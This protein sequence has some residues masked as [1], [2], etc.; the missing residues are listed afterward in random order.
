MLAAS[1]FRRLRLSW[2]RCPYC[3]AATY[4][5][6]S[7]TILSKD[8]PLV[9]AEYK[10]RICANVST[11]RHPGLMN[12]VL[13]IAV[14]TCALVVVYNILARANPWYS[15]SAI[16]MVAVVVGVQ[17]IVELAISRFARR[18]DKT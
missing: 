11:L 5:A 2:F 8:H 13:P 15:L 7:R 12:L 6:T 1:P 4:A 16:A 17:L 9:T 10:C 18:F 14:A 3:A